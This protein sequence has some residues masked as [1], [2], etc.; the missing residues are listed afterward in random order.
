[1]RFWILFKPSVLTFF[2]PLPQ[3]K[4]G[5]LPLLFPG[6]G[7]GGGDAGSPLG[8]QGHEREPCSSSVLS[9]GVASGSPPATTDT[10]LAGGH[11]GTSLLLS[12]WCPLLLC[13]G[14]L[15]STG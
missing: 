1:M 6:V 14:C 12:T 5:I 15:V 4:E 9:G 13:E 2:S 10:T 11:E 8:L 7:V 3:L